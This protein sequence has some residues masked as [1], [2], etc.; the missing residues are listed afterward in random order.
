[1]KSV[2]SDSVSDKNK[3]Q[4]RLYNGK[5]LNGWAVITFFGPKCHFPKICDK[6]IRG[7]YRD[8]YA[9]F[10][11]NLDAMDWNDVQELWSKAYLKRE[12]GLLESQAMRALE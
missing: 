8:H 7:K 1:M 3:A 9:D 11:F 4:N 6:A 2:K 12:S 5:E 10:V